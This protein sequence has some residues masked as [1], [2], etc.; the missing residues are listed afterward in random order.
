MLKE[1]WAAAGP[2]LAIRSSHRTDHLC[3]QPRRHRAEP[4]QGAVSPSWKRRKGALE[5]GWQ[6]GV[7]RG[8]ISLSSLVTDVLHRTPVVTGAWSFPSTYYRMISKFSPA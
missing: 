1:G 7:S 6:D 5:T 3:A 8:A 2:L 4:S